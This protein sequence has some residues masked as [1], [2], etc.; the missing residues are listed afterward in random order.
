MSASSFS[1]WFFLCGIHHFLLVCSYKVMYT[2]Q[3]DADGPIKPSMEAPWRNATY[4]SPPNPRYSL[5]SVYP[6]AEFLFPPSNSI[7]PAV[8]AETAIQRRRLETPLDRSD[9]AQGESARE[10]P[11]VF[12]RAETRWNRGDGFREEWHPWH[13]HRWWTIGFI[14]GIGCQSAFRVDG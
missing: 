1:K 5:L 13:R 11:G 3:R 8:D 14:R 7:P 2:R 4:Y 9:R 12:L 6:G 10:P